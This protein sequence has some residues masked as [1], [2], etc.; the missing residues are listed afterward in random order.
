[1]MRDRVLISMDVSFI[2]V[3]ALGYKNGMVHR[4]HKMNNVRDLKCILNTNVNL[5]LICRDCIG[6]TEIFRNRCKNETQI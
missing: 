2:F 4:S 1:M 6:F 5:T 3:E